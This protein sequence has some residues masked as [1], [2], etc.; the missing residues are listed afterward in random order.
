M[1]V[2]NYISSKSSCN[3]LCKS[4]NS[5]N[6]SL[7][8]YNHESTKSFLNK[9][10]EALKISCCRENFPSN[11]NHHTVNIC[12]ARNTYNFSMCPNFQSTSGMPKHSKYSRP[13]Y[14]HLRYLAVQIA[15]C[16]SL[17]RCT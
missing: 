6:I 3:S 16:G 13:E 1:I 9:E 10:S 11:V 8:S 7:I 17:K 5:K 15:I 4:R 14:N 2:N 12:T